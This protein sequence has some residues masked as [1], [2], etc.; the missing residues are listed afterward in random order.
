M[1]KLSLVP[2]FFCVFPA[3][4]GPPSDQVSGGGFQ[5]QGI[6]GWVYRVSG[7]QMPSPDRKPA[8]PKGIRTM[9]YIFELTN[10][11]QVTRSG[12][13]AFYKA[14]RTKFVKKL[15]TGLDGHFQ[16]Q[17]PAGRYSLFTKEKDLFYANGFDGYNNIAPATVQTG[18]MTRVEIKVDYDANY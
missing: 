15:E 5:K 10:L 17:L 14:I 9:L 3:L 4:S 12:Q 11:N 7:N 13:T 1:R 6:E 2:A 8:T 16:V 18:K